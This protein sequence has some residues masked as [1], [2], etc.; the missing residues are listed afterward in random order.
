MAS[1]LIAL[2]IADI[3]QRKSSKEHP[4]AQDKI[5]DLLQQDYEIKVHRNTL[6]SYMKELVAFVPDHLRFDRKLRLMP[7][8][9]RQEE[10]TGFYWEHDFSE[11]E[12]RLLGDSIMATPLPKKQKQDLLGK[13]SLLNPNAGV[14]VLKS[15]VVAD[16]ARER[17]TVD[18]LLLVIEILNEAITKNLRISFY[19]GEYT[20]KANKL[21]LERTEDS[22]EVDP[23]QIVASG[24]HYYLLATYPGKP[25]KLYHF[26]IDAMFDVEMLSEHVDKTKTS[27]QDINE[28]AQKHLMMFG[29]T[30]RAKIRVRNT[31][32]ARLRM[33]DAFGIHARVSYETDEYVEL[34][35]TAN[36]DALRYWVKQ[37]S[38]DVEAISPKDLRDHLKQD[39][40][41]M[42]KQ[43][44][45][46]SGALQE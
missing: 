5:R 20:P 9:S 33:F 35:V 38:E 11:S 12:A 37:H 31:A 26:R 24:G 43:Y 30:T 4:L 15:I 22:S 36:L 2:C 27:G 44:G 7:N 6:S 21:V 18:Q 28:Y 16:N 3:L 39:A 23:R 42:L 19:W 13:V 29:G 17:T 46:E 1:K 45:K 41:D 14:R 32:R 10:L 25:D 34:E 8:G 40:L